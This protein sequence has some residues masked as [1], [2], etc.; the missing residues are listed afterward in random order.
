MADRLELEVGV[1]VL[2]LENGDALLLEGEAATTEG[3]GLAAKMV[4]A[5]L[6]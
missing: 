1:D 6:I 3:A 4:A 2:L 5:E